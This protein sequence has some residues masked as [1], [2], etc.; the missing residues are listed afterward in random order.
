MDSKNHAHWLKI[1]LIPISPSNSILAIHNVSSHIIPT[2]KPPTTKLKEEIN[3]SLS[4][5][6]KCSTL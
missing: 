6:K 1:I 4:D 3:K 2:E 5:G